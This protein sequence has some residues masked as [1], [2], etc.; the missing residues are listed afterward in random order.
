MKWYQYVFAGPYRT[1]DRAAES[2]ED[3]FA[4]GEIDQSQRPE[5]VTLRDHRKRV[6]GYAVALDD[7]N[8]RDAR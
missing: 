5:V 3:S 8:L 7:V 4:D 6:T 2:M 1:Y